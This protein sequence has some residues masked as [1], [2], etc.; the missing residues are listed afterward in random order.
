[1]WTGEC[2]QSTWD[3]TAARAGRH[4]SRTWVSNSRAGAD[5]S[6]RRDLD[7]DFSAARLCRQ[8][9]PAADGLVP[10]DTFKINTCPLSELQ[11]EL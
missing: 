10:V 1:M 9:S 3:P 8:V 5:F 7:A 2:V 11:V 6:R 4:V